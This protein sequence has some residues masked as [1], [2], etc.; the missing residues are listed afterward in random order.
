MFKFKE[1]K[2]KSFSW[3]LLFTV[4]IIGGIG[5]YLISI[6][7]DSTENLYQKQLM[8]YGI[9]LF[10]LLFISLIDYHFIGKMFIPLYLVGVGLLLVCK[11]SNSYPIYGWKHYT[12]RRWIKIGG[13]PSAGINNTGFE[14]QPSEITKIAMIIVLAKFFDICRKHIKKIWVLIVSAVIVAI[15]VFF[16]FDQPDL[17]TSIVMLLV[18]AAMVFVSGVPYKFIVPIIAVTVPSA[19][20]LLWYVQQDFQLLLDDYQQ[21]RIL[22][23]LYPDEYPELIYQQA[24]AGTAIQSGGLLGKTLTG[25][26][27]FRGTNYVPVKES[28]FIFTAVGE[29]FGFLGSCLVILLYFILILVIIRIARR[30]KDNL[31]MLIALGIGALLTFQ[32]FI[33]IGVVTS[34]LPNTGIP[35]PYM[36][37]GLSSLLVNLMMIGILLNISMQPKETVTK[38]DN[39]FGFIEADL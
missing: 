33:N 32:V 25:D 37:S 26:T 8:G 36:S 39:D 34:L 24:N 30:A 29:E 5:I 31:G 15:P 13:D 6:L 23:L 12:A 3:L 14:F 21:K 9:G 4:Y 19:I 22:S 20:G 7:Q 11:Y 35:L 28:D 16:I 10:V 2:Y 1:Y 38:E 27:S 18:Y 17:S